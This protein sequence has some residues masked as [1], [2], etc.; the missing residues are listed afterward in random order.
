MTPEEFDRGEIPYG[1]LL[2]YCDRVYEVSNID[3]KERLFKI[4]LPGF[5]KSWC[6]VRCEN[7]EITEQD[8]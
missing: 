6:W 7:V 3:F 4:R 5:C 8:Q 2:K 1:T